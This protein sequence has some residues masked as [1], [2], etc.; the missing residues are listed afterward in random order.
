MREDIH[1]T[2][3]DNGLVV[4]TDRMTGVRSVTLGIFFRVGSRNE[5]TAQESVVLFPE[6]DSRVP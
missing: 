6:M 4:L 1:E 3:F 5:P 2:R